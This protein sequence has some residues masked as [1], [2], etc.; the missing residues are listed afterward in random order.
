[1]GGAITLD[2]GDPENESSTLL[3]K[4]GNQLQMTQ[5]HI[6][7]ELNPQYFC[8]LY[9]SPN[10]NKVKDDGDGRAGRRHWEHGEMHT[11]L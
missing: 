2:N 6:P 7:E 9:S 8:I 1:M 3:K 10:I 4:V 5:C 11:A